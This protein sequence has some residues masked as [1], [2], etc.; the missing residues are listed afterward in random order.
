MRAGPGT[1]GPNG[2]WAWA[3]VPMD[4]GP[5]TQG[6]NG[7]WARDPGSPMDPSPS[8]PGTRGPMDPPS[9]AV[10]VAVASLIH[11]IS[12]YIF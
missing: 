12:N 7:P 8:R 1:Q 11:C 2:P 9:L 5:G 10:V 6:P 3:R 4:P